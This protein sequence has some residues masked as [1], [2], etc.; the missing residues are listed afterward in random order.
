MAP[1]TSSEDLSGTTVSRRWLLVLGV[2]GGV[3]LFSVGQIY[4]ARSA[5][6]EPPPL[7]PLLILEVP[8]WAFWALLTVPVVMLARRFPLDR[9]RVLG[10]VA[11]HSAAAVVVATIA[12]GFYMLWYQAYNPYP[13]RTPSVWAWFWYF[14]RQQFIVGFMIYW[15]I[16]GVYHAFT[17]YFLSRV[18]ELE[19]TRARSQ[20]SEARLQALKMQIHPHFL[21]NTLNS[22]SALVEEQPAEARRIV[23]RLGELLRATLRSD[24]RH[25][26]PL[27][28]ELALARDYL[29]IEQI[30]FDDRLTV[31]TDVDP[32]VRRARVPSLLFQPLIENA[33]R[34]GIGPMESGGRLWISAER[35]DGKLVVHIVDDGAGM[36]D[37]PMNEGIGLANV[38]SRLRELYGPEYSLTLRE[39]EKG[40]VD[41]RVEIP[42]R[43]PEGQA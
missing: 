38:R 31:E 17:N 29:G 28:D 5:L 30:R 26:V 32:E 37:G 18:R 34:H 39:R 15:A 13:L 42:L 25:V 6:G 43:L 14:F 1:P 35:L 11:I 20:L 27:E 24:A 22:I 10:S 2:W 40:G 36:R 33:I 41:V 23:A 4:V 21:F 9:S 8:V 12:V 3:A 19:A 7:V 16:V